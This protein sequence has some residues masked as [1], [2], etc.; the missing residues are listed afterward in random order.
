ML[1]WA[2]VLKRCI[3]FCGV[4][5]ELDTVLVVY[6]FHTCVCFRRQNTFVNI[7]KDITRWKTLKYQKG[8]KSDE[9]LATY[10]L[11][12]WVHTYFQIWQD[13]LHNTTENLPLW[14]VETCNI[15]MN[16]KIPNIDNCQLGNKASMQPCL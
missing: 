8:I 15:K 5:V 16:H 2:S 14:K 13:C 6:V 9:E 3:Y 11:N 4:R 12:R 10:L 7:G 1:F